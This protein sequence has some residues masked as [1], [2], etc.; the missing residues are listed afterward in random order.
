[1]NCS[2]PSVVC[3]DGC[4]TAHDGVCYDGGVGSVAGLGTRMCAL[5][6]DCADCG[7]RTICR[8]P[9][10]QLTLP[11]PLLR[12]EASTA[13][14]EREIL[15]MIM[16]SSRFKQRS[17]RAHDSWCTR[18]GAT[19]L[20]FRERRFDV[21]ST[22]PA[23]EPAMAIVDVGVRAPHDCCNETATR[24]AASGGVV[25]GGAASTFFCLSHRAQTLRAQY[26]Y[27]PAL[28]HVKASAAFRAGRFR[29]VVLV[30]DDSFVF[31]RNA[32]PR[33]RNPRPICFGVAHAPVP[34]AVALA[35]DA[36]QR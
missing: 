3:R 6:T 26:R 5:G 35:A 13:L 17:K 21:P 28:Q 22:R 2:I 31:M 10:T 1:M 9:D 32:R 36:T 25:A 8:V 20:F 24:S 18:Q 27:L 11:R 23:D 14:K 16:G 33:E 12:A 29:W 7:P 4:A 19:C 34:L 15:F 30:D